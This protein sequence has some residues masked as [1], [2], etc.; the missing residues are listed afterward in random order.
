MGKINIIKGA[1]ES[2]GNGGMNEDGDCVQM[3]WWPGGRGK[4]LECLY[5]YHGRW[6]VFADSHLTHDL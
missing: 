4:V 6:S 5:T 2:M 3:K 1:I